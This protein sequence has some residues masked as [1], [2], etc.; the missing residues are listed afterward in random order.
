[1]SVTPMEPAP[2]TGCRSRRATAG[3]GW[4]DAS[5]I[6]RC[7]R[8]PKRREA[9]ARVS[10]WM[11]APSRVCALRAHRRDPP[12]EAA[13]EGSI[14]G[15]GGDGH[16]REVPGR[17]AVHPDPRRLRSLPEHRAAP[18]SRCQPKKSGAASTVGPTRRRFPRESHRRATLPQV[19][20]AVPS[21]KWGLT[22]VF[23]MGTGVAPTL[24]TV[25]K[26]NL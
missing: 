14:S 17:D 3:L 19:I 6:R 8:C 26:T 12:A 23:G 5:A 16:R 13:R 7:P 2:P 21:P 1:M 25:G 22:S 15:C 20:P 11:R 9:G 10:D 24:W 4:R 18:T